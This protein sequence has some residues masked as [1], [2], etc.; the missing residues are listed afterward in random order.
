MSKARNLATLLTT[1]GSVKTTKY[2]DSVGGQSTFVASGALSDGTTLI[3]NSDGTVSEIGQSSTSVTYTESIPAGGYTQVKTGSTN[4]ININFD[5]NTPNSFIITYS[6][7]QNGGYVTALVGT[8]SGTAMSFGTPVVVHSVNTNDVE[9]AFDPNT[10]NQFVLLY[11][12]NNTAN[13]GSL[14]VGTISGTT[15]TFN[16]AIAFNS[17]DRALIGTKSGGI[18]FDP[19]NA[20]K[21]L[22][23]YNDRDNTNLVCRIGTISSGSVTLGTKQIF[24][25]SA[26]AHST[27]ANGSYDLTTSGAILVSYFS[28]NGYLRAGTVNSGTNI[29]W[30]TPVAYHTGTNHYT[31]IASS[32]GE[33]GKFLVSYYDTPNGGRG[34]ALVATVSGLT[35]TVG[36]EINYAAGPFYIRQALSDPN[37][38]GRFIIVGQDGTAPYKLRMYVV[39][40]SGTVPSVS[41]LYEISNSTYSSWGQAD[42]NPNKSGQLVTVGSGSSSQTYTMAIAHQL[43]A[44]ETISTPT[45]LTATNFIGISSAAYADTATAT[46]NLQGGTATNLSGLTAGST[47]Y[48]QNDGTLGTSAGNPSVEAGKALST[49]SIL[50]KGIQMKTI[51]ENGTN[52]SKYMFANSVAITMGADSITT[53]D[54]IIG[55]MNT[56][57]CTL[58]EGVT[59]PSGWA[60]C[61]HTFDGTT[62]AANP[63]W[64]EPEAEEDPE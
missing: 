32:K 61:K 44:T 28:T 48:V 35:V 54:F 57:N 49:T 25:S 27:Y 37:T 21:F 36:S 12:N 6:D 56:S 13:P 8:L 24:K 38:S 34:Q 3:L 46:L 23:T 63:D 10:A 60:G 52:I 41:S 42:F 4:A 5:P 16:A 51:I 33:A 1:D 22:L 20:G 9:A 50:L 53:P 43:A 30:G 18:E 31:S 40:V 2:A 17:P 7:A 47:Y 15:V 29:S 39:T 26:A 14:Q 58:V 19:H 64:V 59:S 11:S 55:D 45:N 62:W